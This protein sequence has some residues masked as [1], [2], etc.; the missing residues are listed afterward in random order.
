MPALSIIV[1]ARHV[2]V[3]DI[4]CEALGCHTVRTSP[5][6]SDLHACQAFSS[7]TFINIYTH[8]SST[9][10]AL[11]FIHAYAQDLYQECQ[12]SMHAGQL[13]RHASTSHHCVCPTC[14]GT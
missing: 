8:A 2:E 9:C 12:Y 3:H 1:Y 14:R 13:G 7:N 4:H 10:Q 6:D 5:S 11:S